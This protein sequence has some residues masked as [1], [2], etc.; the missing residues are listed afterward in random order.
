MGSG[1]NGGHN[2]A[3]GGGGYG[4]AA[5]RVLITGGA[6]FIGSHLTEGLVAAGHRVRV[7]DEVLPQAGAGA[8]PA[9]EVEVV[10]GDV[11]ESKCLK[12]ALQGVD[13]IFHLAATTRA[14]QSMYEISR[15]MSVN[16]QG[17]AELL[18]AMLE[19]KVTP[20]KL[21]VASSMSIYGEG[22][23]VCS[24]CSRPACPV[25]RPA[26]QLEEARWEVHCADCGGVLLPRP[27]AE[28]KHADVQSIYALSKRTQEELFLIFGRT[29]G[30]PVTVLRLFNVYGPGQAIANP[31]SGVATQFAARLLEDTAPL[32]FEDGEQMRDFVH[33][34]D[35]VQACRLV[36]EHA[37]ANGEVINV[38]NGVPIRMRRVAELLA[39]ALDKA[40]EPVVTQKFRAGD[41]RHCYA[42]VSKARRLLGYEPRVTHEQGLRELAT[43]MA[44]EHERELEKGGA[45]SETGSRAVAALA[46]MDSLLPTG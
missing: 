22:Q 25:V 1:Q 7:L 19:N 14:S 12:E 30:V 11:R 33:V 10:T 31:Y 32:L 46:P 24:V 23:Y 9:A 3:A 28:T 15:A 38:G 21:I 5:K 42:D 4:S 2:G 27:T 41:L 37:S 8:E 34:R 29:Y 16:A 18:Q 36:M 43:W 6:G 26:A 45:E 17:T 35:V 40:I 20:A 39:A 44:E 13:V